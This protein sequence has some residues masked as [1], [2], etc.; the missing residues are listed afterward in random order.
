M[1]RM[2]KYSLQLIRVENAKSFP[3]KANH[4]W[5]QIPEASLRGSLIQI[6]TH[7]SFCEWL[8]SETRLKSP[9]SQWDCECLM[10]AVKVLAEICSALNASSASGLQDN[11]FI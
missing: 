6:L 5:I 4:L 11:G 10:R 8:L 7:C 9:Y 1:L 2:Q 3:S